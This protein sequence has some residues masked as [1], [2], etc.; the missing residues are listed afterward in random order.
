MSEAVYLS[1]PDQNGLE[2]YWD[3][4]RAEWP[5]TPDGGVEMFTQPLDLQDLVAQA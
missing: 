5:R 1:D 2:L 4:P 3:R